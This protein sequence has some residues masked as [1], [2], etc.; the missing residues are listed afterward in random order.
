[1][2]EISTFL[3]NE[4]LGKQGWGFGYSWGIAFC[5][6]DHMAAPSYLAGCTR[7]RAF[8]SWSKVTDIHTWVPFIKNVKQYLDCNQA[9]IILHPE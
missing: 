9:L 4:R 6:Y 2:H 8:S 5:S 1:M 7:F 3:K